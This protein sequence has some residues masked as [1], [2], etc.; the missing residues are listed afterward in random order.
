MARKRWMTSV[1]KAAAETKVAM[2]WERAQRGRVLARMKIA[3][4][5]AKLAGA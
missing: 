5:K 3:S 1:L 4:A 2:P